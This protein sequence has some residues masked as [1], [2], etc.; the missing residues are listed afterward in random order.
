LAFA[1]GSNGDWLAQGVPDQVL[2]KN[3]NNPEA[4]LVEFTE[5]G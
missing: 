4:W 5:L 2:G 1:T 3:W